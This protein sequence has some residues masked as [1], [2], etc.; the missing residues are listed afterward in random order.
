MKR[1]DFNKAL[2]GRSILW[3]S[4]TGK[5][6]KLNPKESLIKLNYNPK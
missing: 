6:Y 4:G 2:G 3:K 5:M 1:L